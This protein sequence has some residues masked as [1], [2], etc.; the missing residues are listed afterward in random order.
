MHCPRLDHFMRFNSD[1]TISR[2]GHMSSPAK[3]NTLGE[4]ESSE[5]LAN[6]KKQ[7][8]LNQWP[9]ECNRCEKT[10]FING[11]S[12][13]L[14]SIIV[15]EQE[16]QSD[17]LQVSGVLDNVC[18][19]A[20]QTC[21]A[22]HSTKIGKLIS[23]VYPMINNATKFRD[24][25]QD[26]IL[27]LDIS[28]GE[29]SVSKNYKSLLENLPPNL[30]TLRVNTNCAVM[31]P[32]LE[33]INSRGVKVTVTVSFDGVGA[34]HDYIRWPIKWKKFYKNLLEYKSYEL[35]DLNLWTTVNTH[36]INDLENIF[37]FVQ[38]HKFNHSYALLNYPAPLDVSYTNRLTTLAREKFRSSVDTQLNRIAEFVAVKSSNQN[39][40]NTFVKQ[41]D[42][43]RGIDIS[44]F[45]K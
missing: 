18:N 16:T 28:G 38:E 43:L 8:L 29:P 2:C 14:N 40:F 12:I 37:K 3:F 22:S 45:I 25:P 27:H 6:I 39:E 10:E 20:C 1:G 23:K 13:R 5:W 26:R 31:L 9:A 33:E 41:Q 44:N 35:H 42:Q 36:N 4:M 24:L 15:D 32:V 7:F 34:V 19:S 17:Y 11:T 21:S 30:K